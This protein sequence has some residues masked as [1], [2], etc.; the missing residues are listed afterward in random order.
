MGDTFLLTSDNTT[1]A[2]GL[3]EGYPNPGGMPQN[4]V[5]AAGALMYVLPVIVL[6]V[7][8]RKHYLR[9]GLEG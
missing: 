8:L 6:V 9:S 1:L 2:V 3:A 7:S 5:T 4:N